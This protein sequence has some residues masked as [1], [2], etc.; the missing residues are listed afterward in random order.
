M[1]AIPIV[2]VPKPRMTQSDVWKKR[3]SVVRYRE[4]GDQLRQYLGE[5]YKLPGMVN[6][7]FLMP[8]PNS[9]S[10]KKKEEMNG[11]PHQQEPDVDNLAKAVLDHL[12]RDDSYVWSLTAVKVWSYAGR[13][14]I[15][16]SDEPDGEAIERRAVRRKN[17]RTPRP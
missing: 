7:V 8:M 2:P 12:A 14:E 10:K 15:S 13:I 4:F 11:Q 6:M 16:E 3:P 9:W 17:G 5:N 1:I